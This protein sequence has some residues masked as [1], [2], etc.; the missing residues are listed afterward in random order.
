[1]HVNNIAG[2]R[3]KPECIDSPIV[4]PF[5]NGPLVKAGR[6]SQLSVE[7]VVSCNEPI[8]IG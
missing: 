2:I 6:P 8:N 1:M 4:E 3:R 5:L 7:G